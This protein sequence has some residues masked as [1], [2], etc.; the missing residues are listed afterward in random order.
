MYIAKK[1]FMNA[2]NELNDPREQSKRFDL[3]LKDRQTG[4]LEAQEK[5]ESFID[6]LEYGL[7]PTVGWG[8]CML[9]ANTRSIRDVIT[10]PIHSKDN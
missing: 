1:E 8:L 9:F 2:Y 7:P 6:A 10:F 3:Q 5:D 4:D